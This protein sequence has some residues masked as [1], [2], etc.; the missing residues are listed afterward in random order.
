[1]SRPDVDTLA[2]EALELA[3]RIHADVD[4]LGELLF[5]DV[6]R[7]TQVERDRFLELYLEANVERRS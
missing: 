4:R 3:R 1:M 7:L 6:D 5:A 2:A